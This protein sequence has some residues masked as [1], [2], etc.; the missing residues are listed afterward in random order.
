MSSGL[1][2]FPFSSLITFSAPSS[3]FLV[4]R[5]QRQ[6]DIRD[7]NAVGLFLDGGSFDFVSPWIFWDHHHRW[8]GPGGSFGE[9]FVVSR[10]PS[11][12]EDVT[13]TAPKTPAALCSPSVAVIILQ[14]R[15]RSS[16]PLEHTSAFSFKKTHFA[17]NPWGPWQLSNELT[18]YTRN[19]S[20]GM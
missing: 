18:E 14:N 12:P 15:L 17:F 1:L 10:S 9:L 13:H 3:F 8:L 5:F 7:G 19:H 6:N 20:N 11:W 16:P 2:L 4:L